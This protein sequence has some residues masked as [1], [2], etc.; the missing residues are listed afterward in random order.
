MICL[1]ISVFTS[2]LVPA[3]QI[4]RFAYIQTENKQSFY[5]KW[6]SKVWSSSSSGY[7][8]LSKI[9]D[10]QINVVVGFPKNIYPEQSFTITFSGNKDAGFLLKEFGEKG[11]GLYNLQSSAVV[12]AAKDATATKEEVTA[13]AVINPP[14]VEEAKN[15]FGDLLVQVTQDSTVRNIAVEKPQPPVVIK[16][17]EPVLP[18]VDSVKKIVKQE[19]KPAIKEPQ[20]NSKPDTKTAIVDN[21]KTDSVKAVIKPEEKP[22]VKEAK[23]ETIPEVKPTIAENNKATDSV[24]IAKKEVK[25]PEVKIPAIIEPAKSSV[26]LFATNENAESYDYIY[27]T[28]EKMGVKDTVTLSVKKNKDEIKPAVKIE[29]EKKDTVKLQP[30]DE[31][32]FIDIIADT[33]KKAN[34]I[35]IIEPIKKDAIANKVDSVVKVPLKVEKPLIET[36]KEVTPSDESIKETPKETAKVVMVNTD[37]KNMA[38]EKDFMALRKKMVAEDNDDD[39]VAAARKVFKSK[40]FT[41]DQVK[42]LCVLFLKDEGKYKFL[43]AAYPYVYDTDSFKQL[44]FLLTEEYYINRFK[45]MI[46]N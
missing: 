9:K 16:K 44:S 43:D 15:P 40:C 29:T 14:K 20:K 33:S 41:T 39:M 21:K 4:T 38:T 46:K 37:C 27:I 19:E 6:N 7:L 30:K 26:T 36:K 5:V 22:V 11:W 8:I 3:Q 35:P 28:E 31:P 24:A 45:V 2:S 23:K 17:E 10:Q 32:K 12:Y 25:Q 18:I 13:T 1:L 42:N 34:E